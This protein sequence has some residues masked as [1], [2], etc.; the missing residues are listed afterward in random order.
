MVVVVLE[1]WLGQ[2]VGFL[3]VFGG[4]DNI[5]SINNCVI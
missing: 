1:I 5:E 3:Q 2:V 4:V